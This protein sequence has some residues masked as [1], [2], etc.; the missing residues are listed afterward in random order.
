[1]LPASQVLHIIVPFYN[2]VRY[3]S[4]RRLYEHFI[5]KIQKSPH[6]RVYT[7]ELALGG[8]EFELDKS[9]YGTQFRFRTNDELWHKENLVN[10]AVQR[11]PADWKYVAVIDADIEFVENPHHGVTDWIKETIEQL[12]HYKIVQMWK[13][14]LD[15]GPNGEVLHTHLSFVYSYLMGYR[16]SRQYGAW[17]PGF[18]WAYTKDAWNGIGGMFDVAILGSGD[19]IMAKSLI[20]RGKDHFPAGLHPNYYQAILNWE[21]HALKN[22]KKDIGYVNVVIRHFFHGAKKNRFYWSRNDGLRISQFDPWRDLKRDWQG[23]YQLTDR[24]TE[25]RDYIRQYS[26]SRNE[27]ANTN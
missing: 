11:L 7:A 18:A 4:R 25:L 5:Q 20:G 21:H 9:E 13:Q 16:F 24:C 19:D 17:H 1:M 2:H 10:L 26:R 15:L 14:C 22:I 27:D 12:Q 6:A 23:L 3:Q 8:R